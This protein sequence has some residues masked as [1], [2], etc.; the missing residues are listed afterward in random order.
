MSFRRMIVKLEE[1]NEAAMRRLT[2]HLVEVLA[3]RC[4]VPED[5]ARR[6]SNSCLAARL[7]R[8]QLAAS[9]GIATR[10]EHGVEIRRSA[11]LQLLAEKTVDRIRVAVEVQP[12][13]VA[14]REF[15]R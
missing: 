9:G 1:P 10:V 7:V 15:C 5:P 13:P 12:I 6:S 3:P 4:G 14:R 11:L 8:H 2:L